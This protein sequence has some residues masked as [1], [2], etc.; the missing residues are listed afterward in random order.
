MDKIELYDKLTEIIAK[1]TT[2]VV[3]FNIEGDRAKKA[4]DEGRKMLY[5]LRKEID[6]VR[7]MDEFFTLYEKYVENN[8]Q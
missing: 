6:G 3:S 4:L 5:N 1:L 7:A 2:T 8:P